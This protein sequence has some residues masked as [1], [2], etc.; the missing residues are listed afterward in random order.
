MSMEIGSR[1]EKPS[2]WI[3]IGAER[4]DGM[5]SGELMASGDGVCGCAGPGPVQAATIA[6]KARAAVLML[7]QR[8]ASAGRYFKRMDAARLFRDRRGL[9]I[10]LRLSAL[11]PGVLAVLMYFVTPSYFRPLFENLVGWLLVSVLATAICVGYGLVEAAIWLF[12]KGRVVPAV[13][14]L[15]AYLLGWLVSVWIVLLGPAAL[16]LL[17]PRK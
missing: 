16:I 5:G 12:G 13:L 2:V 3:W 6:I 4:S 8:T 1:H 14:L 11:S 17:S 10:A 9:S 15:V 7:L